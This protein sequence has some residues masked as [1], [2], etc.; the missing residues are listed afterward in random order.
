[1]L[2]FCFPACLGLCLFLLLLLS[3]S[4]FSWKCLLTFCG[5]GFLSISSL[6]SLSSLW[7]F[8]KALRTVELK[9]EAFL[10]TL[11]GEGD[12]L[13]VD[14]S[15]FPEALRVYLLVVPD[16]GHFSCT[17]VDL[18]GKGQDYRFVVTASELLTDFSFSNL[19]DAVCSYG[20]I[21]CAGC[22]PHS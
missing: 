4:T 11:F 15:E 1:M 18:L 17:G 21:W 8:S 16:G 22:F 3:R 13:G 6:A 19:L 10:L 7:V 20:N 2:Y 5:V 9:L 12:R 14:V